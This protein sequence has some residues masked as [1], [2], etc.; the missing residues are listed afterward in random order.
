MKLRI[1]K[2]LR[3]W[4]EVAYQDLQEKRPDVSKYTLVTHVLRIYEGRG[5]AMRYLDSQGKIAWQARPNLI[6]KIMEAERETNAE[7]EV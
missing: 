3:F 2:I 6:N 5:L 1:S 7:F 4:V